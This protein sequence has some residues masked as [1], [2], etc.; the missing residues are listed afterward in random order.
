VN[1]RADV[2]EALLRR[3]ADLAG[4][5]IPVPLDALVANLGVRVER[6]RLSASHATLIDAG[7]GPIVVLPEREAGS[8]RDRFSLAHE[9]G[10][11]ILDQIV[12]TGGASVEA[13]AVEALCDKFASELLL[14]TAAVRQFLRGLSSQLAAF[15]SVAFGTDAARKL[16]KEGGASVQAACFAVSR[17]EG[18]MLF[19]CISW[20]GGRVG[21]KSASTEAL[22]VKWS[23]WPSA[24][25]RGLFPFKHIPS[26]GE[27]SARYRQRAGFRGRVRLCLP[28]LPVREYLVDFQPYDRDGKD[29]LLAID[30]REDYGPRLP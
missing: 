23:T 6:S 17:A 22:R 11:L 28:P 9:V 16:A 8:A 25:P 5:R 18:T 7:D 24:L 29:Y 3:A 4:P 19:G 27:L 13:Q 20:M 1:R 26:D 21:T 2:E 14:P 12:A 15:E 10:H 30:L